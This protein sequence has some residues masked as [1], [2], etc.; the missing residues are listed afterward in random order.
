MKLERKKSKISVFVPVASMGDIAFLLIIFFMLASNF[1]KEAHIDLKKPAS[2][3]IKHLEEAPISVSVDKEGEIWLQGVKCPLSS[4][5]NGVA[6]LLQ[7]GEKKT[8]LLKVDQG[9]SQKAFGPVILALSKAG[10]EIGMVG[11]MINE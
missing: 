11:K 3:D 1:M 7:D 9:L 4:L 6:A 10:A 8:V 5:E 2:Q